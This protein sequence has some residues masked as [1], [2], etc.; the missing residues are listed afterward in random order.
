VLHFPTF[1]L[2]S[3]VNSKE[4][5]GDVLHYIDFHQLQIENKQYLA[6]IEE[7]NE[8]LLQLKMTTGKTVQA[9]NDLKANLN[10]HVT[11]GDWLRRERQQK[12]IDAEKVIAG[13]LQGQYAV[14]NC[15]H[16]CC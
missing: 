9:L 1:Q 11:Q 4:E 14:A 12:Q 13:L 16:E 5:L 10:A 2:E 8:E 6:K 15:R 3:Q 7:K